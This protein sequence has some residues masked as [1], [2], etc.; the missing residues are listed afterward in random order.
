MTVTV[1]DFRT[2]D[3]GAV[4]GLRRAC[5]PFMVTTEET[6]L[7]GV[8]TA[9]PAK[10]Y[11]LLVAEEDGE[12]IGTAHVGIAYDSSDPGQASVTPQVHPERRGRGAGS[13]ILR[14][15][16]AHL[17]AEGATSVYAWVMDEPP[18]RAFAERHGYRPTRPAHFQRL[19]LAHG[20]LPELP[21]LPSGIELRTGA[22]YA[23]DPRPLFAADAEVCSDEPGD[24]SVALDDYEDWLSHTWNDPCL[25]RDLTSVV[26]AD[27]RIASF[28]AAH[29][30]GDTR[31]ASGMTGT[32]RA[33]RGR[34][35][36]KL[37]KIHSLRRARAA[38]YT[39]AFTSNDA[40]NG[41]ML[42]INRW[43]GYEI[44]AT[45]VRHVRALG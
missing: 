29:T 39:D 4:V 25:D 22:D 30:D 33:F 5:T 40:D 43:F 28:T 12:I 14:T 18:S 3:V 11:R 7:A 19:D 36:A 16:E 31:Y 10:K 13:L 35:L 38:G 9:H 1:R 34:G 44:C 32:L 20:A 41:P 2:E 37:A 27:G 24:I 42:A 8:A 17:A 23:D 26:V 45:E 15:A 21:P 6:L